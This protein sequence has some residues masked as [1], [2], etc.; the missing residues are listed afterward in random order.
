MQGPKSTVRLNE[1]DTALVKAYQQDLNAMPLQQ[2]LSA[3]A[4]QVAVKRTHDSSHRGAA[5]VEANR[6]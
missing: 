2:Y 4:G 1:I 5:P 6:V 3:K